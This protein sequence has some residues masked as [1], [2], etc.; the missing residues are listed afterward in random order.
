MLIGLIIL[1]LVFFVLFF[2]MEIVFVLVNKLWVEIKKKKSVCWGSI[3]F[4]FYNDLASF[5][6][7][8]F[9]GNNIVFVLFII[10][11]IK[12]IEFYF[13]EWMFF[14]VECLLAFLLL[15]MFVI[16][17]VVFIFGEFLFKI[18][19]CFFVD[20]VFYFLAVFL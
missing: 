2:G 17:I 18:L 7:I 8:M 11:M 10:F 3:I 14:L 16:I 4:G 15:E 20:Q 13:L 12:F 1:F 6:G 5:F 9:V 19:F